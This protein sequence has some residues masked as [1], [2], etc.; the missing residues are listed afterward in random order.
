MRARP[1]NG[2]EHQSKGAGGRRGDAG[3][4]EEA[5]QVVKQVEAKREAPPQKHHG[6]LGG[7]HQ[8][9]EQ[10]FARE[11]T[12]H[13]HAGGQDA[14]EGARVHLVEER[15][16]RPRDRE[17]QEH[18]A[19]PG[20][21]ERNE[22]LGLPLA[23]DVHRVDADAERAAV[24]FGAARAGRA[25]AEPRHPRVDGGALAGRQGPRVF[26]ELPNP[27]LHEHV[28]RGGHRDL[29]QQPGHH[30]RRNRIRHVGQQLNTWGVGGLAERS[31]AHAEALG[32]DHRRPA[33]RRS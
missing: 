17:Q 12:R 9:N 20:G 15:A 31:R 6:E 2:R 22:A 26:F 33:R 19:D 7:P 23:H 4:D 11:Q 18:H 28:R 13:P 30:L 29:L 5:R 27:A 3:H 21:V 16:A 10:P 25:R 14:V 1:R 8:R 24:R 32:K